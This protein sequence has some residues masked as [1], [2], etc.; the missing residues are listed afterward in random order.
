[1]AEISSLQRQVPMGCACFVCRW[2]DTEVRRCEGQGPWSKGACEVRKI[3]EQLV[4]MLE[5]LLPVEKKQQKRMAAAGETPHTPAP[6]AAPAAGGPLPREEMAGMD[7]E[8]PVTLFEGVQDWAEHVVTILTDEAHAETCRKVQERERQPWGK[9]V[10]GVQ[11]VV[12][13]TCVASG[14]RLGTGETS[15]VQA[16]TV[17]A[18]SPGRW[19]QRGSKQAH[20]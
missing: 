7:M 13:A 5:S 18:T 14:G 9:A 4:K 16:S 11:I 20:I 2:M 3:R 15:D 19:L 12:G 1:M 6:P 10:A 8:F 17:K